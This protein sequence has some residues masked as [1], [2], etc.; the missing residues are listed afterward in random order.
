MLHCDGWPVSI[1]LREP[2]AALLRRAVRPGL[3]IHL[4]LGALLDAIVPDRACRVDAAVDVGL[5]EALDQ[6]GLDG[7]VR[8]DSRVAIRLQ[9]RP[10]RP[11]LGAAALLG[12]LERAEQILDVVAVLVREHVGLGKRA[13]LGAEPRLELVEEA[14][15]DVD[16]LVGGAVER[17][18][19]RARVAAARLHRVRVEDRLRGRVAADGGRSSRPG[20]C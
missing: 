11:A 6:P 9:L 17:A 12:P 16:L 20:C 18:D 13:A 10:H 4:A 1:A 5:G 19:L 3:G 7:V 14:E 2:A 8:P 15:V